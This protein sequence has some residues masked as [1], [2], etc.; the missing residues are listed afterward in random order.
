MS[1]KESKKINASD[2]DEGVFD[3]FDEYVH[4]DMSRR[5]FMSKVS[6]YAV[7][8]LTASA[9]VEYLFTSDIVI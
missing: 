4:S 7:A 3:L 8:G 5:T 9:I 6:K 2:L 1:S